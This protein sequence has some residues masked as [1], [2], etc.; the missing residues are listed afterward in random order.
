MARYIGTAGANAMAERRHAKIA[1]ETRPRRQP[2]GA[3]GA[4]ASVKIQ[5]SWAIFRSADWGQLL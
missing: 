4:A 3:V 2:L 1:P 5:R